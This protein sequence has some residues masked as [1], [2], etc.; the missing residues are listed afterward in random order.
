[1]R[2]LALFDRQGTSGK[3]TGDVLNHPCMNKCGRIQCLQHGD[4]SAA[5]PWRIVA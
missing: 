3:S 5:H 1:M 4:E 2:A